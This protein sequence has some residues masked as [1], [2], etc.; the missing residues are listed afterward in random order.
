LTGLTMARKFSRLHAQYVACNL[1]IQA[2]LGEGLLLPSSH[3]WRTPLYHN[4]LMVTR[5]CLLE[6]AK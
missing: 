2:V 1:A 6:L 5:Q 4:F 3:R